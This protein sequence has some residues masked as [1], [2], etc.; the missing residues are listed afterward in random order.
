MVM[1]IILFGHDSQTLSVLSNN[2]FIE[3]LKRMLQNLEKKMVPR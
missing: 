1:S 3:I 2:D